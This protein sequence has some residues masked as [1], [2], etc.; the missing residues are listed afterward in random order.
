[1]GLFYTKFL[2]TLGQSFGGTLD[3]SASTS[4]L[5]RAYPCHKNDATSTNRQTK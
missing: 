1:M 4:E 2:P 5:L 3:I